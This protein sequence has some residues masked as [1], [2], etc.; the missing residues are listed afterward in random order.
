MR[1][2]KGPG[3]CVW[4]VKVGAG[5][6]GV[7]HVPASSLLKPPCSMAWFTGGGCFPKARGCGECV[8]EVVTGRGGQGSKL[9]LPPG[10]SWAE[11][12]T[13]LGLS[14]YRKWELS[15]LLGAVAV[16]SKSGGGG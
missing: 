11:P 15:A 1:V 13:F 2:Q 3:W 10:L 8:E 4:V 6:S 5:L 7:T 16:P 12:R 9:L 14:L